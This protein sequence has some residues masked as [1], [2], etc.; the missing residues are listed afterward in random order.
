MALHQHI[1][2]LM[3]LEFQR[4]TVSFIHVANSILLSFGPKYMLVEST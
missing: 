4:N 3:R 1:L 2:T